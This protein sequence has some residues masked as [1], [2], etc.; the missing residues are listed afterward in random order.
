MFV[1]SIGSSK[2]IVSPIPDALLFEAIRT[3]SSK[4]T[5]GTKS[6]QS[7]ASIKST[8]GATSSQNAG[9]SKSIV[10][11]KS[12]KK[13]ASSKSSRT[14]KSSQNAGSSAKTP[15][16]KPAATIQPLLDNFFP[17]VN[18]QSRNADS[19]PASD[20]PSRAGT[21]TPASTSNR[22][23][24]NSPS[25][26][27]PIEANSRRANSSAPFLSTNSDTDSIPT[28]TLFNNRR[29]RRTDNSGNN[30]TTTPAASQHSNN[31]DTGKLI[32]SSFTLILHILIYIHFYCRGCHF[33][34][35]INTQEN[36]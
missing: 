23:N 20:R 34:S 2:P 36:T 14:A 30:S 27:T 3:G 19:A 26:P 32:Y 7:A 4:S 25:T 11:G 18:R 22:D 21:V 35:C 6:S 33:T 28:A 15:V 16:P 12:N 1:P 31:D 5:C 13:N 9:S 24:S 29:R 10:T 8:R 17:P